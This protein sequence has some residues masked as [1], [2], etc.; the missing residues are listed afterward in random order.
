[1]ITRFMDVDMSML[2]GETASVPSKVGDEERPPVGPLSGAL[3]PHTAGELSGVDR[4][5]TRSYWE[6]ATDPLDSVVA[7]R[8]GPSGTHLPF[9]RRRT[10]LLLAREEPIPKGSN[11]I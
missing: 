11:G 3:F 4:E 6:T 5:S 1:M 8:L 10:I 7:C 9:C 2:A